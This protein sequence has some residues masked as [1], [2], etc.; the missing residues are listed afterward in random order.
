MDDL[1]QMLMEDGPSQSGGQ[2]TGDAA[3]PLTLLLQNLLGDGTS[4]GLGALAGSA[5][6]GGE[7]DLASM[8]LQGA[9][10]STGGFGVAE[11]QQATSGA[12]EIGDLLGAMMGGAGAGQGSNALLA[13]IVNGLAENI[14]LPPQLAQVVVSFVLG[15]LLDSR[16]QTGAIAAAPLP[17][18]IDEAEP[19][20][21]SL[22]AA[23]QS[24]RAGKRTGQA[25]TR[26]ADLAR[27][28]ADKTGMDRATAEASVKEVL[29]AFAGRMGPAR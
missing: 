11:G 24:M 21:G 23:V 8:L 27:E 16:M 26:S 29:S 15:K 3:D 9:L 18:Q 12:G 25:G 6:Q 20:A 2:N 14:G 17:R 19:E 22:E 5:P 13:P 7:P 28:L 1:F 4:Q 10:G